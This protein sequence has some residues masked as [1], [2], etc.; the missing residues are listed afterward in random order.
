M[1]FVYSPQ[2][3]SPLP[4]IARGAVPLAEWDLWVDSNEPVVMVAD[5]PDA[6]VQK[7]PSLLHDWLRGKTTEW[8]GGAARFSAQARLDWGSNTVVV[9][10]KL[11]S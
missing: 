7:N 1:P 6:S 8:F 11:A 2:P 9:T 10:G 3:G 4:E 5:A